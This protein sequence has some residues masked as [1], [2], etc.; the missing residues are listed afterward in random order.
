MVSPPFSLGVREMAKPALLNYG[1][2]STS[3]L[4]S[5]FALP[6]ALSSPYPL[7]AGLPTLGATQ[8][9]N[10]PLHHLDPLGLRL[11]FRGDHR[12]RRHGR[13]DA[14]KG[15]G[16]VRRTLGFKASGCGGGVG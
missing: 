6:A 1:L 15:R 4:A 9:S 3:H 16:R 8:Y 10:F 5:Q 11:R 12:G 2:S 7:A 13:K 14:F